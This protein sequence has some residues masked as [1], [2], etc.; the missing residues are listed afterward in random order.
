MLL[1]VIIDCEIL[2]FFDSENIW[3]I[4]LNREILHYFSKYGL[5]NALEPNFRP[6]KCEFCDKSYYR[7]N[8]FKSHLV[9]CKAIDKL[10]TKKED[11]LNESLEDKSF[12]SAKIE[13]HSSKS[14]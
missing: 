12:K 9:K 6:F 5:Y 14:L 11:A 7:K 3:S 8:V 2:G 10:I 1:T 13:E 4:H